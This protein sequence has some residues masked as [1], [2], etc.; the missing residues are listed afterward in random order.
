M[1]D[2][3]NSFSVPE[4]TITSAPTATATGAWFA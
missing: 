1:L 2:I 4:L 3:S